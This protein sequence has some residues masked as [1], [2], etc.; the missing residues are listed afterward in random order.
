M[1]RTLGPEYGQRTK[2]EI[3][4]ELLGAEIVTYMIRVKKAGKITWHGI[5][6]LYWQ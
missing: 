2:K 4:R 3:E 6:Y 5:K 1:K